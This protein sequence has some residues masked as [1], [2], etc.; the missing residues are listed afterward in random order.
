MVNK[1]VEVEET[2]NANESVILDIFNNFDKIIY[3]SEGANEMK[4]YKER[5]DDCVEKTVQFYQM[6]NK[7]TVVLM[8]IIYIVLF[9]SILYLIAMHQNKEI[10]NK[11]FITFFTIILLYREKMGAL[12]QLIPNY[13]E[14]N[15]RNTALL[16]KIKDIDTRENTVSIGGT[17]FKAVDLAFDK[18]EFK[19]ITFKYSA[20]HDYVLKNYSLTHRQT[21]IFQ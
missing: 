9:F 5:A 3:R 14:F 18:I 13:L 1:R 8:T 20:N 19:N 10:D 11:M 21:V 17:L 12:I 7:H 16:E 4:Y 2:M 15:A 6:T